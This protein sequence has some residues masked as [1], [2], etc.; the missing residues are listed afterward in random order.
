MEKRIVDFDNDGGNQVKFMKI[1]GVGILLLVLVIVAATSTFVVDPGYRGIKVVMGQ[2]D[3]NF[4]PEGFG[5]K[6]PFVSSIIQMPVRQQTREVSTAC[7][8]SDLQQVNMKL[9]VLY[10]IPESSVV[11]VYREY[12]GD[13]FDSL[14]APRVEEALKEVVALQSAELI[15]KKREEI[16]TKTLES[17]RNKIGDILV[18]ADIV[19]VDTNLSRELEAAIE[20]KM[21]QEQEAAKAKF[22]QQK[23]QIEA[24]TAVV[25]AKGEA[26]SIRIRAEALRNNP[27]IIELQIVEKWDGHTPM[28]VG[29]AGGSSSTN[30]LLPVNINNVKK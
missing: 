5:F 21:V 28:V 19:L 6:Q 4:K 25:R 20:A 16:K 30:I 24:D 10:R 29:G 27:G 9:R 8:S 13:P 12:L 22:T 2:V 23:A 7:Y 1:I 26:E 15:V 14:I 3:S 17:A 11:K 18:I